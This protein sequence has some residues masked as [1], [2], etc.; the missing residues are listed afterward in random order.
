MHSQGYQ[1]FWFSFSSHNTIQNIPF[2]ASLTPTNTLPWS[3]IYTTLSHFI[4][5]VQCL[6][7]RNFLCTL[8]LGRLFLS[9]LP[10]VQEGNIDIHLQYNFIFICL[11]IYPL[12]FQRSPQTQGAKEKN[13]LKSNYSHPSLHL[14]PHIKSP[15]KSCSVLRS[16][17]NLVLLSGQESAIAPKSLDHTLKHSAPS[18]YPIHSS[19]PLNKISLQ[20]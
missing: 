2:N 12:V 3:S 4:S 7:L 9:L 17:S 11:Q 13:G 20:T 6:K 5:K 15:P 8:S 10:S 19:L 18:N 1:S 16:V 14:Q